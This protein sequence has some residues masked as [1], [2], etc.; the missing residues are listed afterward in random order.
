MRPNLRSIEPVF[1]GEARQ[2]KLERRVSCAGVG[3]HSGERVA[4]TLHPASPGTG[5]V[6]R[7]SDVPGGAGRI[8][9][10]WDRV[11]D[12]TRCSAIANGAGTRVATVEHLMAAFAGCEIDN[13]VVELDGPEV[14]IMD[15]S[16]APFVFLIECA[17]IVS[18]DVGRRFIRVAREVSVGD[19]ERHVRLTP[20]EGLSVGIEIDFDNPHVSRQTHRFEIDGPAFRDELCRARTF[21][22][23][24]DI[25]EMRNRGL[26]QGG[27]LR[28]AVVVGENGV[29]NEGGLRYDDEFVRHKAL[30]AVGDLYLAGAPIV[31]A[32]QG[33]RA[34]HGLNNVLLRTLFSDEDAWEMVEA[35]RG[36]ASAWARTAADPVPLAATA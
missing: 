26:A 34:S 33:V 3:L 31:G 18:Q 23:A 10:L 1:A 15:G 32:Y 17:G 14:P 24:T 13:A 4:M 19:G 21:G 12:T 27:S 28:N 16:A 5:I 9:A 11:C 22:F 25:E 36:G 35:P 2:H 29:I 30:D 8:P 7:R 6:F 20:G